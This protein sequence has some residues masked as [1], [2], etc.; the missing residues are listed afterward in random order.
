[1]LSPLWHSV[2]YTHLILPR[3]SVLTQGVTRLHTG[4]FSLCHGLETLKAVSWANVWLM[5]FVSCL[6]GITVLS[7]LVVQNLQCCCFIH[8]FR[9]LLF[10]E[11]GKSGPFYSVLT[12]SGNT[13]VVLFC[14]SIMTGNVEHILIC[15]LIIHVFSLK[16][17]L[18]KLLVLFLFSFLVFFFLCSSI[19]FELEKVLICLR[20]TCS[21]ML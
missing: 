1:M 9:F 18:F 4:F 11:E 5:S 17:S 14:I 10:H 16:K 6:P 20:Y 7:L 19:S 21:N 8:I 13:I 2:N 3:L 12:G 15:L